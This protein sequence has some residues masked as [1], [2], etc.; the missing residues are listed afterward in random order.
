MLD[1]WIGQGIHVGI[2][3]SS[4]AAEAATVANVYY[5]IIAM[6]NKSLQ[7]MHRHVKCPRL[8]RPFRDEKNNILKITGPCI[9]EVVL[10]WV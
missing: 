4:H 1:S 3:R 8:F 2:D 10:V 5:S 9:T 7:F 6:L